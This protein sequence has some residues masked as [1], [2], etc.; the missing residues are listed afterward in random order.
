[1][2]REGSPASLA[3]HGR[4]HVVAFS[5]LFEW[6]THASR[7]ARVYVGPNARKIHCLLFTSEVV[8]RQADERRGRPAEES[9]NGTSERC[10]PGGI[11]AACGLWPSGEHAL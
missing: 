1:M 5:Q 4:E 3:S 9:V 10:F 6:R 8:E 2:W 7:P 11:R